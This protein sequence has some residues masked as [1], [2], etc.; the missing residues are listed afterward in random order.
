MFTNTKTIYNMKNTEYWFIGGSMLTEKLLRETFRQTNSLHW[1]VKVIIK[2]L[3]CPHGPIKSW[4]DKYRHLYLQRKLIIS[5]IE[6]SLN[7]N[8]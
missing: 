2:S 8:L 4:I 7:N 6:W 1:N 3:I 5:K